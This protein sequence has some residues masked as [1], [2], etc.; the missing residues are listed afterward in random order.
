MALAG[1]VLIT[2]GVAG[3]FVSAFEASSVETK[4]RENNH[5]I[6]ASLTKE[7]GDAKTS[8]DRA[9]D[10]A[11]RANDESDRATDSASNALNLA[12][13]ARRE[14]D[15]FGRKISSAKK[16]A[17]EAESHLSEAEKRARLLTAELDRLTTPRSLPHSSS[18]ISSLKP[19]KGTEY[20]FSSVCGDT[21]CFNLLKDI[22]SVLER[23]GWKRIKTP[24]VFPG[25]NLFGT[26][27]GDTVGISIE[28]GI[29]VSI[30]S[31][32]PLSELQ[33]LTVNQ[34][35]QYVQAAIAL[36]RELAS[37]VLRLNI[38][39]GLWTL[40]TGIPRLCG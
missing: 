2:V 11:R 17:S 10:A 20:M 35:P 13:S 40:A 37:H 14:A 36:N 29:K 30:Q 34:L 1:G 33:K 6:E 7:A 18:L 15:S 19:F 38:R 21:E 32:H 4:L 24:N 9:A 5:E 27:E 23:A 8:A 25:F 16:Q 26:K 22:D 3:E 28:P 12:T 39:G 31:K